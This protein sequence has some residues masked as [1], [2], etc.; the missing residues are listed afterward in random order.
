M[1]DLIRVVD[2]KE[3]DDCQGGSMQLSPTTLHQMTRFT[4]NKVETRA[5]WR[6]YGRCSGLSEADYASWAE[7][8]DRRMSWPES[9]VPGG[10]DISTSIVALVE[11]LAL[12]N[13]GL[14]AETVVLQC[15]RAWLKSVDLCLDEK[16]SYDKAACPLTS[17]CQQAVKV[18]GER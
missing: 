18:G 14:T 8:V 1:R 15:N 11:T 2:G 9:L 10:K 5:S 4:R 7:F 6:L 13:P 12:D 3:V 16:F 17:S